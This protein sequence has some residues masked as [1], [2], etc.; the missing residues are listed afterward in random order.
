MQ[1]VAL[2]NSFSLPCLS[3]ISMP[4]KAKTTSLTNR[5]VGLY[6]ESKTISTPDYA[7][8]LAADLAAVALALVG[9]FTGAALEAIAFSNRLFT[10]SPD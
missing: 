7:A 8:F 9:F 5:N 3:E 4:S 1:N 2:H 10:S 6:K